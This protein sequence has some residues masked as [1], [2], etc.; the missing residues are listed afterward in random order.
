MYRARGWELRRSK[1]AAVRCEYEYDANP[2]PN[3]KLPVPQRR[4]ENDRSSCDRFTLNGLGF[5]TYDVRV[6][7]LRPSPFSPIVYSRYTTPRVLPPLDTPFFHQSTSHP[8][9]EGNS[10]TQ[11][12]PPY[13]HKFLRQ[14]AF[15]NR[16]A[17]SRRFLTCKHSIVEEGKKNS[18]VM[19]VYPST[20]LH[21]SQMY[22]KGF[23][24][25]VILNFTKVGIRK[26][27]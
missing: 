1:I 12:Q 19:N 4:M 27:V 13:I 10:S 15:Y 9:D 11:S 3:V 26:G 17:A 8:V 14:D 7:R 5:Y 2:N 25:F 23:R 18:A 21:T 16:R 20:G 24:V 6:L 22:A